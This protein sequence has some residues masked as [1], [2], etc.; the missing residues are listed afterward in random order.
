MRV[1]SLV[2]YL[3]PIFN[4]SQCS[5]IRKQ[6]VIMWESIPSI[7]LFIIYEHVDLKTKLSASRTCKNWREALFN[8]R[9]VIHEKLY[10]R[11]LC[12]PKP[13]TS[14]VQVDAAKRFI[15]HARCLIIDWCS[16]QEDVLCNVLSAA[17]NVNHI[18]EQIHFYPKGSFFGCTK[19]CE[20]EIQSDNKAITD[21]IISCITHCKSIKSINFGSDT[22]FHLK[23]NVLN[24][25]EFQLKS[26]KLAELDISYFTRCETGFENEHK[27]LQSWLTANKHL[28]NTVTHL[29]VTW[30]DHLLDLIIN[31]GKGG[32]SV[33]ILGVLV[34]DSRSTSLIGKKIPDVPSEFWKQLKAQLP[35]LRVKLSLTEISKGQI[36]EVLQEE[37]P[38]TS[39]CVVYESEE[40]L[41][42]VIDNLQNTQR[43]ST[44]E[45]IGLHYVEGLHFRPFF[46][47]QGRNSRYSSLIT[48]LEWLKCLKLFSWSGQFIL[49]TDILQFL[50]QHASTLQR[51]FIHKCEVVCE[52]KATREYF[53]PLAAAKVHGLE[54]TV[55][56]VWGRPW[57]MIKDQPI[58]RLPR[59]G[60]RYDYKLREEMF[61]VVQNKAFC[62]A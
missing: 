11:L 7:V 50:T 27:L 53:I 3:S 2:L 15:T 46:N 52:S 58:Q 59:R 1:L 26:R 10:V 31:L 38:L 56:T 43:G 6:C 35:D 29:Y 37:I 32:S 12:R 40:F 16:C 48:G 20:T 42:I 34:Q 9:C 18:T 55:S 33:K 30:D 21:I 22:N 4:L 45:E 49:D 19:K 28:I 5:F 39:L 17:T 54:K 61:W 57:K 36:R 47:S 23:L 13:H 60:I 14:E 8:P 25:V 62:R 44:L 41:E 51:L 24:A